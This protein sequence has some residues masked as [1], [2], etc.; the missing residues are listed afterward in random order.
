MG[1]L[2]ATFK[3]TA[4]EKPRE[5]ALHSGLNSLNDGELLALFLDTGSSKENVVQLANRMLFEKGGLKAI[6]TQ[7]I[8]LRT[9]GVKEGKMFRILACKE[10]MRR[11]PYLLY[12]KIDSPLDAYLRTRNTFLT[13]AHESAIVIYLDGKKNVICQ[14]VYTVESE[15]FVLVPIEKIVRAALRCEAR[16]VILIHNHPSG[17]LSPSKEDVELVD[18]LHLSLMVANIILLDSLIINEETYLS[19]RNE[20]IGPFGLLEET[21]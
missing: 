12:E 15:L 11:L 20:K 21:N 16:F 9:Y 10:V 6:F 7:N 18:Q 14:E 3:G 4:I 19:M 8:D 1:R 13:N 5:K 17:V 2:R